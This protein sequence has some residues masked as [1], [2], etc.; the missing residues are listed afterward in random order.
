MTYDKCESKQIVDRQFYHTKIIENDQIINCEVGQ[1]WGKFSFHCI[2]VHKHIFGFIS[3]L[4][5]QN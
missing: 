5:I 3:A 2:T 4:P 1:A